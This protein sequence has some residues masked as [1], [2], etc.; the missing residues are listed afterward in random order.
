MKRVLN[1]PFTQH[2][3]E[4]GETYWEHC[5]DNVSVGLR[6]IALGLATVIHGIFPFLRLARIRRLQRRLKLEIELPKKAR[7]ATKR[8]PELEESA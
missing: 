8:K 3:K 2:P 5:S 4:I 6:C 7:S 1:N